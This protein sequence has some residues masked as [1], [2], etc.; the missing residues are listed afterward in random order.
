M[1]STATAEQIRV[2]YRDLV[3]IWHP[4][5]H[6]SNE[7]LRRK[8]TEMLQTINEAYAELTMTTRPSS[9]QTWGAHASDQ[10]AQSKEDTRRE[11]DTQESPS[12]TLDEGARGGR[13]APVV[14]GVATSLLIALA[15]VLA[16]KNDGVLAG[17]GGAEPSPPEPAPTAP[18]VLGD[19]ALTII[20]AAQGSISLADDFERAKKLFVAPP[21]SRETRETSL[22]LPGETHYGWE[23]D[24]LVFDAFARNGKLTTLSI[25]QKNLDAP[26]RQTEIDRELERFDEPTENAEGRVT[27]AYVWREGKQARIVVEFF[28]KQTMG[29]LRVVGT[30]DALEARG[31]PLG[32]LG[33]LVAA[34]DNG[35]FQ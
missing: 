31:F 13:K 1:T 21:G 19:T 35:P 16:A 5:K 34:F 10:S 6:Q 20:D 29:I 8:A 3:A 17:C 25:L 28:D 7:R 32:D 27:A 14:T 12:T 23:S 22:T 2:A 26:R 11:P 4:D 18:V 15:L 24:G 33:A 30:T 9:S